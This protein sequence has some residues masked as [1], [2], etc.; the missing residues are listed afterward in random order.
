MPTK[1]CIISIGE[2]PA[3]VIDLDDIEIVHFERVSFQTKNFDVAIVFKDFQTFKRINAVD[4]GYLDHLKKYFEE[5]KIL[6]SEGHISLNWNTILGQI[7]D[8][9][10]GFLEEGGWSF[11]RDTVSILLSNFLGFC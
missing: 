4:I 7:R 6:H 9:F 3:F 2:L 5:L 11:L 1:N 10:E 8:D